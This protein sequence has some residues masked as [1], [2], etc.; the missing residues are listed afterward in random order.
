MG[1]IGPIR[2]LSTLCYT[3]SVM[4]KIHPLP[5]HLI[6]KIA[7]GEVIE[8][9][10]Y[11]IK[12]LIENSLDAGA[13]QIIIDLEQSG[14]KKIQVSDNGSGMD[15]EDLQESWKIHTTSKVYSHEDLTAI[16]TMGFRGEALS[17]IAAMADL[18][19]QSRT[20]EMT[21]GQQ[22]SIKNGAVQK[23]IPCGIP[24][25]TIVTVS[26]LFSAI[27]ARQKFLKSAMTETRFCIEM[28]TGFALAYPQV[29]FRLTHNKKVSLDVPKNQDLAS[30]I[31]LLLGPSIHEHLLP[32]FYEDAYLSISG[33]ISR[34]Q[35][36]TTNQQ[37]S[38]LFINGR[39]V[40]DKSLFQAIKQSYGTIIE[41]DQYPIFVLFL[42]LPVDM[43]DVNVH[44]RKEQVGLINSQKVA[45]TLTETIDQTLK[46]HHLTFTGLTGLESITK[47]FAGKMLKQST[48]TWQ[49][50]SQLEIDQIFQLENVY[51]VAST[52][53]GFIIVDQHAAHE[54][55]L[56]EQYK[57]QFLTLTNTQKTI[58]P[59]EPVLIDLSLSD[60]EVFKEYQEKFEQM[61][62]V[63][64]LFTPQTYKVTQVPI[65]FQ[66]RDI[67]ILIREILD[68]LAEDT[69]KSIDKKTDA[70]LKYLACRTAIKAGDAL[71]KEESLE[72][73]KKLDETD[74][75]T[76]CPH[77]RPTRIEIGLH[78][79]NR[80]F[81]RE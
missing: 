43:V 14:L 77:G 44:P 50:K 75:N 61:G 29:S 23:L 55:I 56:Y 63:L 47:S 45:E 17:S 38:Y 26:N 40:Y 2:R 31:K 78:Q 18:T 20:T 67:A 7:A 46:D 27:P 15:P 57:Q 65:L 33:F 42:S 48:D 52:N 9:P 64:E 13:D 1:P 28:V 37:K 49:V 21:G 70:I 76:T 36:A 79:L 24:V 3:I 51:L 69:S 35:I 10:A 59:K 73:I 4:P 8:R 66:D 39:K 25:G 58:T 30:R 19:I 22:L 53:D 54:R 81:R 74:N 11:V 6:A 72:L 60:V 71:S 5:S 80:S 68:D 62:F 34:P 32:I 41:P 12:E 16:S